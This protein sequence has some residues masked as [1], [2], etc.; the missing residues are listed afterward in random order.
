MKTEVYFVVRFYLYTRVGSSGRG[1]QVYEKGATGVH[2][3]EQV[4]V[5]RTLREGEPG[6]MWLVV[7]TREG[8]Q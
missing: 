5:R 6:S 8:S 7:A 2:S 4:H 3:G 1:V